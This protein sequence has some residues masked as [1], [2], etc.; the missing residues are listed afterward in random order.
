MPNDSPTNQMPSEQQGPDRQLDRPR[1]VQLP[2]QRGPTRRLWTRWEE[3]EDDCIIA[4]YVH[5]L[6]PA[7]RVAGEKQEATLHRYFNEALPNSERT[8]EQ[9]SVRL[10]RVRQREDFNTKVEI[11][12]RRADPNPDGRADLRRDSEEHPDDLEQ[13]ERLNPVRDALAA[14]AE[15][16]REERPHQGVRTGGANAAQVLQRREADDRLCEKFKV[17]YERWIQETDRPLLRVE[18]RYYDSY[19]VER[20]SVLLAEM[21]RVVHAPGVSVTTVNAAVYTAAKVLIE[22][23]E[24]RD[25]RPRKAADEEPRINGGLLRL[26]QTRMLAL[27]FSC[28]E[29]HWSSDSPVR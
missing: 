11:L 7:N 9:V 12:R 23:A 20:S 22:E 21:Q 29:N 25:K 1:H 13:Q 26:L 17:E 16:L 8:A 28:Q 14:V 15:V 24:L 27:R 4:A 19:L 5:W 10:R 18:K 3:H 6:N 2:A